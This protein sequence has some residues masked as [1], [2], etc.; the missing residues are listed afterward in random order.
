VSLK[1]RLRPP[2]FWD[3]RLWWCHRY[4]RGATGDER[5]E[6]NADGAPFVIGDP[7]GEQEPGGSPDAL[8]SARDAGVGRIEAEKVRALDR[9]RDLVQPASQVQKLSG[10]TAG[11]DS[12]TQAPAE[13]HGQRCR[14][15]ETPRFEFEGWVHGKTRVVDGRRG[16]SSGYRRVAARERRRA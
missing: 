5:G 4:L 9:S 6:G 1:I 7:A 8:G 12:S 15:E 11:G 14:D 10:I 13:M 3:A 16:H 2:L